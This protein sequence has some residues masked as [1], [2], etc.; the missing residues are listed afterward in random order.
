MPPVLSG[1]NAHLKM[2]AN[3]GAPLWPWGEDADHE[4]QRHYRVLCCSFSN[5]FLSPLHSRLSNK[6]IKGPKDNKKRKPNYYI[7]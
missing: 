6:D 4:T 3:S 7:D 2:K 5:H 1:Y